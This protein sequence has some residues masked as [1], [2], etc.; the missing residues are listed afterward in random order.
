M[1]GINQ[2]ILIAMIKKLGLCSKHMDLPHIFS[3]SN[4][5]KNI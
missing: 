1:T 2:I 4:T 5:K 3:N